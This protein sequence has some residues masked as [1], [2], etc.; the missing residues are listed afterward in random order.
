MLRESE[1]DF[2]RGVSGD[3]MDRSFPFKLDVS[4]IRVAGTSVPPSGEVST[5][6]DAICRLAC[7]SS[8]GGWSDN[9]GEMKLTIVSKLLFANMLAIDR[10]SDETP[11]VFMTSQW[12]C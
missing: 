11:L 8:V 4:V 2:E 5:S 12:S 9:R 3:G 6:P 7:S 10:S 1:H